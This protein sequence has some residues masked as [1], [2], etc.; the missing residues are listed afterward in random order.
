MSLPITPPQAAWRAPRF[1]ATSLSSRTRA[2]SPA[3][4]PRAPRLDG[5]GVPGSGRPT[6]RRRRTPAAARSCRTSSEAARAGGRAVQAQTQ[7]RVLVPTPVP[8][9]APAPAA[10]PHPPRTWLRAGRCSLHLSQV[11]TG[12]GFLDP[13]PGPRRVRQRAP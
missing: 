2:R 10:A 13:A 3:A 12:R 5:C 9:Q 4:P 8:A 7:A 11:A 1:Q 6:P